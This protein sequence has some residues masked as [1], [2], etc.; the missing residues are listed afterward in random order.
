LPPLE[1]IDPRHFHAFGLC[2]FYDP[3]YY[4]PHYDSFPSNSNEEL[5][6]W[7]GVANN[8]GD[9]LTFKLLTSIQKVVFWSVIQ[10]A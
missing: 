3:V 10:L 2:G 5:G 4:N 1:V 7:V 9:A 8:F 6:D